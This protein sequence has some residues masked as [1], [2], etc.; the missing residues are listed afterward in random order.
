MYAI[1]KPTPV[2]PEMCR[3]L[4]NA[5]IACDPRDK[6][7]LDSR[8]LKH[9]QIIAKHLGTAVWNKIAVTALVLFELS[10]LVTRLGLFLVF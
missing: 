8:L 5:L 1:L 6:S 3:E 4:I 7:L 9:P 2:M 10:I